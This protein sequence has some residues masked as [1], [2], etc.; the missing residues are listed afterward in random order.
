MDF[1]TDATYLIDLWRE[2]GSAG[3]ATRFAVD[4]AGATFAVP[5]V[6]KAE[7]LR[8]ALCARVE[9]ERLAVF[10]SSLLTV[11][12]SEAT[13]RVYADLYGTLRRANRLVGPHDLWVAACSL[14]TG[15]PLLSRNLGEFSRV[16]SLRVVDYA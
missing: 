6:C 5:W 1:L 14:D 15:V 3:P 7:F 9:P 10:L 12:P 4:H 13:L 16:P 11:F 8:G 2:R